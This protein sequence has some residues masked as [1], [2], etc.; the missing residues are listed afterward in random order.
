M[1]DTRRERIERMIQ[2]RRDFH[3]CPET[4]W[5]EFR[6]TAKAAEVMSA[7]GYAVK[8][9]AEYIVP[10]TVMGRTIDVEAEEKRA[11]S[12]GA[13]PEWVKRAGGYTGLVAELDTGRPGPVVALRFDIDGVDTDEADDAEHLPAR[14][15]FRSV[16]RGCMHACGHDGHTALGL[17][18]AEFVAE[19]KDSLKGVVRFLFQPAEEGVRGGYAMAK[20]G[21]VDDADVF[22]ALHLG[23]GVPTGTVFGGTHGFLCTTKI[24]VDFKGMGAH[25]GGEPNMGKNAL[26]AAA[27]A[28]LNLHAIAPH[29]GGLTRINV[30]VLNAGEG[31][32]VIAPRA[33]MKIETRGETNELLQ[34][35]YDRALQVLNGASAMYDCPVTIT[36][37]GEANT[38]ASDAELAAVVC[39]AAR[40]TEGVTSAE[41]DHLM[42]G[43]DDAC[44]LMERV[45]EHGGKATYIGL[46][47]TTAAGHHND[48]FDFD[49]AALPIGY[50]LLCNTLL[51]LSGR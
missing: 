37:R 29:R 1:T 2:R 3:R 31:R 19:N 21:L 49:E 23:L 32:N 14:E 26:L 41:I 43:S 13:S 50:D 51:K 46:G 5:A 48:R 24:D 34:Y 35:V 36:K 12:Q 10:E 7:L 9:G 47:A 42:S 22:I 8:V 11:L 39:E 44:W 28:A 27:T 6:T 17:A 18:L 38:T 4:G 40:E 25:A 30:G 16:N 15:G 33:H 45:Q 20:A